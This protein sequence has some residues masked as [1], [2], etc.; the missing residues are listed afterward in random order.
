MSRG[1]MWTKVKKLFEDDKGATAVEYGL[2]VA[3]IAGVLVA[4]M[5]ATGKKLNNSFNNVQSRL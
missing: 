4:V 3:A 2:I 5:F 1:V